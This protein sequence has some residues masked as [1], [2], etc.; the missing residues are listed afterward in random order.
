[1][2]TK[3]ERFVEEYK[4]LCLKH[5][6][7]VYPDLME[8]MSVFDLS[9]DWEYAQLDRLNDETMEGER[10]DHTKEIK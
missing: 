2:T 3:F 9:D 6:A 5:K 1:M 4:Q 7:Y 10:N 8:S